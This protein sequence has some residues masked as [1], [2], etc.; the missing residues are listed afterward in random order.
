M[1]PIIKIFDQNNF[2]IVIHTFTNLTLAKSFLKK[3]NFTRVKKIENQKN[4]IS[5]FIDFTSKNIFL[6]K[7]NKNKKYQAY[8]EF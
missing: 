4:T 5:E 1:K 8:L 7:N 3:N 2:F 6:Y